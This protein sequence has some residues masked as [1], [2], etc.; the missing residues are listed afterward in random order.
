[1]KKIVKRYVDKFDCE[2]I[3]EIIDIKDEFQKKGYYIFNDIS[4]IY[5]ITSINNTSCSIQNEFLYVECDKVL[6]CPKCESIELST[7]I[8]KKYTIIKCLKCYNRFKF[9]QEVLYESTI[10]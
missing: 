3:N 9:N 7:N 1:M 8:Q 5:K 4:G 10:V 6:I 2:F